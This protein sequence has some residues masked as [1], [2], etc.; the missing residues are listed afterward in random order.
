MS[1]KSSGKMYLGFVSHADQCVTF[2]GVLPSNA[3]RCF[4]YTDDNEEFQ[5]LSGNDVPKNKIRFYCLIKA[6]IIHLRLGE[7]VSLSGAFGGFVMANVAKALG[8]PKP[9][10]VKLNPAQKKFLVSQKKLRHQK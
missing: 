2:D 3:A 9:K 8:W 5:P 10:G 4:Y 6:V 1:P 7:S